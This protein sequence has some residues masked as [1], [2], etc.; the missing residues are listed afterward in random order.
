MPDSRSTTAVAMTPV[1]SFSILPK[2]SINTFSLAI[3]LLHSVLIRGSER[4]SGFGILAGA[5]GHGEIR[6]GTVEHEINEDAGFGLYWTDD[7]VLLAEGD[8]DVLDVV[9]EA[10][11]LHRLELRAD[12]FGVTGRSQLEIDA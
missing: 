3:G 7:V 2:T 10:E 4:Q 5:A 8:Q 11:G 6:L 9:R 1:T 12:D